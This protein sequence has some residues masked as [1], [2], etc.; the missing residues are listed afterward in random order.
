MSSNEAD[1]RYSLN[2][3]TVLITKNPGLRRQLIGVG[4]QRENVYEVG[5][6][7]FMLVQSAQVCE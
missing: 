7:D 3:P 4:M 6:T 5:D 2:G 1:F